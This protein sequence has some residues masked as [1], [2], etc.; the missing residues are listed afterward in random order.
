MVSGEIL[1]TSGV[2]ENMKNVIKRAF[3]EHVKTS[4]EFYRELES[5]EGCYLF[6]V[7]IR[8]KF[9]VG[10]VRAQSVKHASCLVTGNIA[11]AIK[12]LLN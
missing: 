11:W 7:I 10:I 4:A 12:D 9:L 1:L 2:E 3:W 8:G 6:R 5:D